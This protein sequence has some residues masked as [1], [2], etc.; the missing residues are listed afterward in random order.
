MDTI[1]LGINGYILKPVNLN[2]FINTLNEVIEKIK[3]RDEVH[4]YKRKLES[5]NNDL[6]AQVC[7][8]I[9]EIYTLNQEIKDTQKEVIF[10]MGTI[11]EIRSKETG[12]HVKRVA[13]YSEILAK[14]YGLDDKEV[15]MLKEASPMHDIGKVAIPD[16][17]LNKTEKLTIDEK[18]IMD[19]HTTLGY[20][21]FK[22]S[23]REL[24]KMAAVV[25]YEH[26]EKYDGSG[27]PRGLKGDDISIYGRITALSDVF[28]ALGSSRVY[29]PAWEDEKI[30]KMFKAEGGKHF[31]PKL[32]DIFFDNL[33]EFL[34]IR[35]SLK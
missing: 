32:V 19:T 7:Q 9:S 6:E 27:Y 18:A 10:T 20:E 24:L 17:I 16:A 4:I 5:L 31:D 2:Q 3:L 25:S 23:N 29:K 15:E 22:Y 28:D 14:H 13:L 30:F 1:R 26:H 8:R 33:D 35:D 21:M 11:G 34:S 12:N